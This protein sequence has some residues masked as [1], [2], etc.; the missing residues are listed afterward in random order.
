MKIIQAKSKWVVMDDNLKHK[1]GTFKNKEFAVDKVHDMMIR[2]WK[3]DG[4]K[5][6]IPTRENAIN[7]SFKKI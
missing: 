6:E 5:G 3:D 2:S 7:E 4:K 1:Y